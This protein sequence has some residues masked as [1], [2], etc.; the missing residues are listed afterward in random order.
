MG[1]KKSSSDDENHTSETAPDD[2]MHVAFSCLLLLDFG[3]ATE[4]CLV[5][6]FVVMCEHITRI[7]EQNPVFLVITGRS[8]TFLVVP[9]VRKCSV[10]LLVLHDVR[11]SNSVDSEV[12]VAKVLVFWESTL[13]HFTETSLPLASS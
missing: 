3:W 13:W 10:G 7:L 6:H 9:S 12:M 2:E 8:W 4:A 11:S 5:G 1:A